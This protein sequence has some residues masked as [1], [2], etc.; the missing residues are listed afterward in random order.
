MGRGRFESVFNGDF[1]GAERA[2]EGMKAIPPNGNTS[3]LCEMALK[4]TKKDFEGESRKTLTGQ[5]ES[6]RVQRARQSLT[7]LAHGGGGV[8]L[9]L[10][11]R[12]PPHPADEARGKNGDK[13]G[14]STRSWW[15]G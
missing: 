10:V 14:G 9:K 11:K 3:R 8:C 1:A 2:L 12:S 7:A 6:L 5:G 4:S 15:D 13:A